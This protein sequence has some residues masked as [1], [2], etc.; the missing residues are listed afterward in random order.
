MGRP[1]Q[2]GPPQK[3]PKPPTPKKHRTCPFPNMT[4]M[5]QLLPMPPSPPRPLYSPCL[6][7]LTMAI[8]K[9]RWMPQL[10]QKLML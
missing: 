6:P 5:S 1:L 7:L 10:M 2:A 8:P 4:S 3:L 9:S